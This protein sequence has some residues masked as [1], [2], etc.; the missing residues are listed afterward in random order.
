MKSNTGTMKS[1]T[2]YE[3]AALDKEID[4][5]QIVPLKT[6]GP[7]IPS[8]NS[9]F[10]DVKS[11]LVTGLSYHCSPLTDSSCESNPFYTP[12][13]N[14]LTDSPELTAPK[15]SIA[16]YTRA[17]FYK[18]HYKAIRDF[19]HRIGLKNKQ[20]KISVNSKLPE[21]AIGAHTGFGLPGRHSILMNPELGSTFVIGITAIECELPPTGL[22]LFK[23][24]LN[25]APL[26]QTICTDCKK[27]EKSCPTAAIKN[28][29]IDRT[30]CIQSLS[31]E[32][33]LLPQEIM[34]K[35]GGRFYGC[36]V[37][38]DVC[39]VNRSKL[40][41]MKRLPETGRTGE[42]VSL[43]KLLRTEAEEVRRVFKGNQIGAQWINPVALH[44]NALLALIHSTKDAHDKSGIEIAGNI[45]SDFSCSLEPSLKAAAR[46]GLNK[47]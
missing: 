4:L 32:G 15:G 7:L 38:Q 34:E 25:R 40:I 19:L 46:F 22:I 16:P 23:K 29:R 41:N 31:S 9:F 18:V 5:L 13:A 1:N 11:I 28:Q 43:L 10:K 35:W 42:N 24:G 12:I 3:K 47:K 45:L 44:R 8:I 27:C 39:P 33:G 20:F 6:L 30:K 36:S 2:S 26:T 21:K 14:N 17:N 37:C